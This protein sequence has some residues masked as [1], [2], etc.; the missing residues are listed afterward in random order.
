MV[1]FRWERIRAVV[2]WPPL[3]RQSRSLCSAAP[4][5]T[6]P[7]PYA[8]FQLPRSETQGR[9]LLAANPCRPFLRNASHLC[10]CSLVL[11]LSYRFRASSPFVWPVASASFSP[12]ARLQLM[13]EV[14]LL[15]ETIIISF[16]CLKFCY[17]FWDLSDSSSGLVLFPSGLS[18]HHFSFEPYS[19][20]LP[21]LSLFTC[22]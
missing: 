11:R 8:S 4:S 15:E 20:L 9:I 13:A 7:A 22:F 16:P 18:S 14:P 5:P 19:A 21:V 1:T 12:P 2:P 6:Q 3:R 17:G 10:P